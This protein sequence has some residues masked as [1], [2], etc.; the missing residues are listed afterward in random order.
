MISKTAEEG[1]SLVHT[2][3]VSIITRSV[4]FKPDLLNS[5]F[6]LRCQPLLS[7]FE[8]GEYE[9]GNGGKCIGW[10]WRNVALFLSKTDYASEVA[11]IKILMANGD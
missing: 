2:D 11:L 6:S 5:L 10:V 1:S 8:V 9:W 3:F 7:L 4:H